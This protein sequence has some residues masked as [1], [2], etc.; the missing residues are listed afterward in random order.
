NAEI[1]ESAGRGASR[2]LRRENRIPAI[3]YGAEKPAQNI[4]LNHFE[5]SK[6][7][8]NEAVYSHV[9]TLNLGS[10]KQQIVLKAIQRH[11]YKPKIEHMDLLRIN[12]KEK[13]IMQIPIHFKGEADAPGVKDGGVFMHLM[14]SVEVRCL[15]AN[16]PE[17]FEVDVSGFNVDDTLML[18]ELNVPKDVEIMLFAHGGEKAE[19]DTAVV[20]LHIPKIE[21]EEEPTPVVAEG[22]EGAAPAEG[23]EGAAPGAEGA[24]AAEAPAAEKPEKK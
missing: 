11:P 17:F 2:R 24:P 20:K 22:E 7:L 15:P 18:S 4:S 13:I 1:R 21:V 9:L 12:P 5:V 16:L 10:E 23:T 3:M 8:E 6:M 14:S 19:H